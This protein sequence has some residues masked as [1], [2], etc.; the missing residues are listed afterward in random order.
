MKNCAIYGS[1]TKTCIQCDNLFYLDTQFVCSEIFSYFQCFISD[2]INDFCLIC[3]KHF[4]LDL[5]GKCFPELP[6][7]N[8]SCA[9]IFYYD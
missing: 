2:G 3:K 9:E 8:L 7:E 4:L 1:I 5:R 6:L